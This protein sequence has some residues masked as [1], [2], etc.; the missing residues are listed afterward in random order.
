MQL[1]P[2]PASNPCC[3]PP[4]LSLLY[5]VLQCMQRATC[6][7]VQ[8]L[9]TPL[10]V[11]ESVVHREVKQSL[12]AGRWHVP[13]PPLLPK[14]RI[15]GA[16]MLLGALSVVGKGLVGMALWGR[17]AAGGGVEL[18]L[19]PVNYGLGWPG[20]EG[21]LLLGLPSGRVSGALRIMQPGA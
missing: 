10:P 17:D 16:W 2:L 21:A 13:T 6:L 11:S 9:S 15:P 5:P 12:V 1:G 18:E 20:S 19:G 14:Q 8:V 3:S 7:Q 4:P